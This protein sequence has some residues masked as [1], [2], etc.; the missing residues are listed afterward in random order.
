VYKRQ[1]EIPAG[2]SSL[3]P[4]AVEFSPKALGQNVIHLAVNSLLT[5]KMAVTV[6]GTMSMRVGKSSGISVR[7]TL[8]VNF[9]QNVIGKDNG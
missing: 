1:A 6:K 8:P 5:A 7:K 2:A 3:I 9:T 4:L